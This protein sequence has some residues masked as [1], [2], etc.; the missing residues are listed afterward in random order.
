MKEQD[1]QT[2]IAKDLT[3][4]GWFVLNLIK[5]N[6]DGI[7]DL[8]ATKAGETTM[9]IECKTPNGVISSKQEY[10]LNQLSR[11]GFSVFVSRGYR[12]IEWVRTDK[13]IHTDLF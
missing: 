13:E 12:I 9:Y 5:T 4:K 3:S 10:R 1:Y 8:Q 6:K 7:P 11:L 2:K